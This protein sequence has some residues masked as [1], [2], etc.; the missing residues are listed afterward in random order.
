M[1]GDIRDKLPADPRTWDEGDFMAAE[2]DQQ[3]KADALLPECK[4]CHTLPSQENGFEERFCKCGMVHVVT[5]REG[6]RNE[7]QAAKEFK[8]E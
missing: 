6:R 5:K 2:A 3:R 8:K 4:V 1:F 7:N